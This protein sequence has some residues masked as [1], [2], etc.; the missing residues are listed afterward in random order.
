MLAGVAQGELISLVLFSLYVNDIHSHSHHFKLSL[1]ADAKSIITTSRK[2]ALLVSYLDSHFNDLHKCLSE[3]KIVINVCKS[4][5]IIFA[6]ARGGFLQPR[7]ETLFGEP[8]QC[9][10]KTR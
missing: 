10:D 8:N 4:T 2:P 5:V 7:P 9:V 1:Y 3:W 6:R